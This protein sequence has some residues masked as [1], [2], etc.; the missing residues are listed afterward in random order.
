LGLPVTGQSACYDA[1]GTVIACAGTGQN[2]EL[3]T[4]VAWPDPR[5]TD[6]AD[7]T[8]TDRLTGLVWSRDGKAPGPAVCNPGTY[9]TWQEALDYVKCL[10]SNSYLGKRDWRLPN[11]NELASLVNRGQPNSAVWL[12]TQG[13][14]NVDAYSYWSS[15]TFA[16]PTW[17]AWRVGMHDGAVTSQA[18]KRSINV[19][20]VRGGQ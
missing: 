20:P 7:Q 2:G 1:N 19:W 14:R 15:T 8:I 18:H 13:F 5:F 3:R 6:N 4:G 9:K 16:Y 11:R 10:N 17:N 12:N